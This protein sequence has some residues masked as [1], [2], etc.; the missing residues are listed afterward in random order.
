MYE[1]SKYS[2]S[3]PICGKKFC[4]KGH[5]WN[6]IIIHHALDYAYIIHLMKN[7]RKALDR[8]FLIETLVWIPLVIIQVLD[9]PLQ[10]LRKVL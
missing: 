8:E 7:H 2:F 4:I 1:V 3:C 6:Q 5:W 9:I 10:I